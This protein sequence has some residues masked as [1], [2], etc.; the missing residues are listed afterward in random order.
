MFCVIKTKK[1]DKNNIYNY[2]SKITLIK[3]KV[4]LVSI[5][6]IFFS[7]ISS[8]SGLVMGARFSQGAISARPQDC[9]FIK[10][11]FQHRCFPVNF[12]KFLR[13]IF[14]KEHVWW[15]LLKV[16]FSFLFSYW[17]LK[18]LFPQFT[19]TQNLN[20]NEN[21][22]TYPEQSRRQ[23]AYTHNMNTLFAKHFKKRVLMFPH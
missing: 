10:K 5:L 22:K 8:V 14:S 2:I 12:V 18:G 13:T 11:R 3:I 23:I 21:I 1:I 6:K 15:L 4:Y 7:T 9:N 19:A 17:F 20:F 16:F